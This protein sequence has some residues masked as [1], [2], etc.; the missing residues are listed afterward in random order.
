MSLALVTALWSSTAQSP[1]GLCVS[2]PNEVIHVGRSGEDAPSA[3]KRPALLSVPYVTYAG[4]QIFD[5]GAR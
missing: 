1:R 3:L 4:F 2:P 5:G